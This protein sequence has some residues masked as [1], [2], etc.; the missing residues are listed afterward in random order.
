MPLTRQPAP[1]VTCGAPTHGRAPPFCRSHT[2]LGVKVDWPSLSTQH[3]SNPRPG[4]ASGQPR[5]CRHVDHQQAEHPGRE[6]LHARRRPGH[7]LP[8]AADAHRREQWL[9]QDGAP[10][11]PRAR[12]APRRPH[13]PRARATRQTIIECI[14]MALTGELPPDANRGKNFIHDPK[15]QA[16]SE[17]KAAIKLQFQTVN[18][19]V[20]A[21]PARRA[22]ARRPAPPRS[23]ARGA[24]AE[25]HGRAPVHAAVQDAQGERG[26]ELQHEQQ[27]PHRGQRARRGAAPLPPH[28]PRPVAPA[29]AA[30]RERP[31]LLRR[32]SSSASGAST[33]TRRCRSTWGSRKPSWTT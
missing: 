21:A 3:S 22:P 24:G 23:A 12:A 2:P 26:A 19:K 5:S 15:V 8:Q 11:A 14:K 13:P 20:R 30:W 18:G 29:A 10:P 7:R 17:T 33:S 25:V 9:G 1:Y 16:N 4:S 32:K 6:E 28:P 31:R 27:Q